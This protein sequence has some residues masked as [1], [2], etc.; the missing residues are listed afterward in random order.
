MVYFLTPLPLFIYR[1]ICLLT[2]SLSLNFSLNHIIARSVSPSPTF[3]L[4]C[5]TNCPVVSIHT[6]AN[7]AEKPTLYF[8]KGPSIYDVHKKIGFFTTPSPCPHEP[9]PS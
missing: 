9:D 6:Q 5:N 8:S 4:S 7:T 1:L 2:L 3:S